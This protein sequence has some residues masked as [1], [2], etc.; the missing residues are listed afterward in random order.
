MRRWLL[1]RGNI[2]RKNARRALLTDTSPDD[3]PI[4]FSNDGFLANLNRAP[5]A[6]GLKRI[7]ESIVLDTIEKYTVPYRYRIRL[8]STSTR[9]IGLVHPAAQYRACLFYEKYS[10]LIPYFCRHEDV[11]MRRPTKIGSAFFYS[12]EASDRKKYKGAAIDLL[13]HDQTVKNPGS[14]FAYAR[15]DRF[16][17]FFNSAVFVELEKKFSVMRL[18]DVSKCFSS[19]YSHTMAW[20]IKDVQHGKENISAVS[21]ANEF[22]LL[23]QFSN[24][25]ETNGIPVGAEISRIFAEIILQSVDSDVLRQAY[26]GRLTQGQD[27]EIRRYIDDYAIFANS[28]EDLDGLQRGLSESLQLLNL[29]LNESK[30]ITMRRPLQTRKSQIIADATVGLNRF[31]DQV[32]AFDSKSQLTFPG[33]I[34]NPQS[35]ARTLVNDMK[36]AC[37]N[38]DAGYEDISPFIIGSICVTIESLIGSFRAARKSKKPCGDGAYLSAFDA[39]LNS[40]Y[41]FFTVHATVSSSYQVARATIVSIRFFKDHVPKSSATINEIVRQ[42]IQSLIQNPTLQHLPMSSYVPIEVLNILLASGELPLSHRMNLFDLAERT[43]KSGDV[44]YFS[45]VSLLFYYKDTDSKMVEEIEDRLRDNFLPRALPGKNSHDAHFMLDLLACP[46][47]T[48]GFRKSVLT[49]L[50]SELGISVGRYFSYAVID[51]IEK[52]PWFVNWKQILLN[53]LRKKEL[54]RVY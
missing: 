24:Y 41:Y 52:N 51:E 17:K 23:M 33:A 47:L 39:L 26:Q 43:L 12:N 18:T 14:F 1:R 44:D 16:Y 4:V 9:Q 48:R 29:Y 27:F 28:V 46:Y 50:F 30:T 8:T 11:S 7:I 22:D 45:I 37:I 54:R 35:L 40:L 36:V 3:V 20:A 15:Y 53:H 19:I 21:F 42:L 38:A 31:R 49:R 5:I 2:D 34:Q 13:L 32:S 25:N 10:H 6:L